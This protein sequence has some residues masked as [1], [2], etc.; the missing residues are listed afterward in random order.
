MIPSPK[1]MFPF[2]YYEIILAIPLKEV[3]GKRRKNIKTLFGVLIP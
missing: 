3:M 1:I 2:F